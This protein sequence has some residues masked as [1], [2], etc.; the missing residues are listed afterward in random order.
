M[1]EAKLAHYGNFQTLL[2]QL[3]HNTNK[4]YAKDKESSG[5]TLRVRPKRSCRV[6][7]RPL[8]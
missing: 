6:A 8:H 4:T 3:F 7:A 1:Y 5:N 2:R